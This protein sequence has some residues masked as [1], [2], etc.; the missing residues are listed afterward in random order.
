MT[1]QKKNIQTLAAFSI[2]ANAQFFVKGGGL[3]VAFKSGVHNDPNIQGTL[4]GDPIIEPTNGL[5]ASDQNLKK[6]IQKLAAFGLNNK[7]ASF[8]KGGGLPIG[9][10]SGVHNDPNIQGGG[11]N[12]T[13]D[14]SSPLV[15]SDQNLKKGIQKLAAFGLNGKEA[16]FVKGGGLPINFATKGK[17]RTQGKNGNTNDVVISDRNLKKGIQKLAAFGLNGK[18]AEFVKGGGL[19]VQLATLKGSQKQS[20]NG[21]TN[22]VVISDRNLKKGIQKLAAFGLNGKEAEFVKGGGLPAQ[23]GYTTPN[24]QGGGGNDTIQGG[25]GNDTLDKSSPLVV[26]DQNLKKGIQK[27][28]A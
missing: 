16:E 19:P 13:L 4:G 25:G 5:V 2:D 27:M 26:S 23:M 6:N 17:S 20:K 18:E 24:I 11:G 7:E 1:T 9:F 28:A 15:V 12:D 8:L 14:K 10:S 22:D 3:P 21:N